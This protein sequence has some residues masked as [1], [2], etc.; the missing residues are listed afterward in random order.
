MTWR[1]R[2]LLHNEVLRNS[3]WV[4]EFGNNLIS[5]VA[6][7][8]V[9]RLPFFI[10][11]LRDGAK[12][13]TSREGSGNGRNRMQVRTGLDGKMRSKK[14]ADCG[15]DLSEMRVADCLL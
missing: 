1:N 6:T 3:V 9:M 13:Q 2:T 7:P 15:E 12:L 10:R 11:C 5:S 14:A 4:E 8:Y